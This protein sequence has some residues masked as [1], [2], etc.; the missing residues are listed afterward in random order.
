MR[1]R[2]SFVAL[3]TKRIAA[4]GVHRA[5][6][7]DTDARQLSRTLPLMGAQPIAEM[8]D[9]R[10]TADPTPTRV[11]LTNSHHQHPRGIVVLIS[12]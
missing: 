3:W 9:E 4:P 7:S 10:V 2:S 6:A 8:F 5:A 11:M 1:S 12:P